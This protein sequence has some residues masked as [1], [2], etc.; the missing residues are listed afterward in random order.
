MLRTIL[1][2]AAC[3][4]CL[5]MPAR[6]AL[7][8]AQ[9]DLAVAR[10]GQ[11]VLVDVLA[12]DGALGPGLRLLKAFKPAHGSVAIEN[13]RVRYTPAA[14]FQGSDSFR[15]MAQS[16][17]AQPG[18]AT[19]SVEVGQAGV[20]LRL[21]GKVTDEAIPF[22]TVKV[23]LGGFDFVTRADAGGNYVLDVSALRGD[24]FVTLAASGT[25]PSGA[26]VRFYSVV[27]EMVRLATAA[28]SDGVLVR[29]EFNQVNI[30]NLST[31]Q[32]TLLAEANGGVP[33]GSDQ[34]LL[35]LVQNIDLDRMLELAAVIKLV[36]D[37]NVAL[38]AGTTD[39]LALIA[40]PAALATFEGTLAPGQLD[41]ALD[42]VVQDPDLTPGFRAGFVPPS[43]AIVPPGAPGTIRVG[44]GGFP[45]FYFDNPAG[46]AGSGRSID[47]TLASDPRFDWSLAGGD[48]VMVYRVPYAIPPFGALAIDQGC[49]VPSDGAW[50][51]TATL[52]RSRLHRL[53]DGAGVDYV[54][55]T[56]TYW[57]HVEDLDPDDAC[58]APPDGERD[59]SGRWLAF[60][61]GAGELP[62]TAGESLGRIATGY[63]TPGAA[64]M[65]AA[66]FDFDAGTIAAPGI[67][68]AF[69]W[70][71][72][73]G[74]LHVQ[75]TTSATGEVVDHEFR[76]YQSDGRKGEGLLMVA[77]R[78][79]G[80][81]VSHYT[82]AS[83]ID[84]SAV[85]ASPTMPGT[86][87]SGFDISQF[88]AE[89]GF[90]S[91][92]FV[93]VDGSAT[94][95]QRSVDVF[96]N[97]STS[98]PFAWTLE[99]GDFVARTYREL[100][101]GQVTSCISPDPTQCWLIRV[102]RWTPVSRDGNRVY[103]LEALTTRFQNALSSPLVTATR[104]NFYEPQ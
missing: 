65:G 15:Y 69:G 18:Q 60:E 90:A 10:P 49:T 88:Q 54:E 103:V 19:V 92:F 38:P 36:V 61:D 40:D 7:Q 44:L 23:S 55:Q 79:D 91:G 64:G 47:G 100:G 66:I 3:G 48:L 56:D 22:A 86:W 102:R 5:A 35:P 67:A 37:D 73:G 13:G 57:R 81:Q 82:L 95:Y 33:V 104:M 42:A 85:F 59:E 53:Q 12:N 21:A 89:A 94:G 83:R 31:A 9:D 20:A 34:Q 51:I 14:G 2:T 43:Y 71:I 72:S 68:P 17:D 58:P 96:G 99:G 84:G 4:L 6:S 75:L 63:L 1:A 52:L 76:R 101:R 50:R 32:Y 8:K 70:S 16:D 78:A 62:F 28:G 46:S 27:G 26:A 97:T 41:A 80:A 74:R 25:A 11:S 45:I 30:T 29:D 93:V 98:F 39:A 87:R 24:A 77:T